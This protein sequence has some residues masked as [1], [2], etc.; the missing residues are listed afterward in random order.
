[1]TWSR[2]FDLTAHMVANEAPTSRG[3]FCVSRVGAPLS[4]PSGPSTTVLLGIA[5]DDQH[6]LRAALLELTSGRNAL[7]ERQRRESGKLRFCFQGNLGDGAVS[8]HRALIDDF[9]SQF[10]APPCCN[11]A[12]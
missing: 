11:P 12:Q 10:G 1:M 5:G 3:V 4:Y 9:T 6:G 2:W 7:V 8:L